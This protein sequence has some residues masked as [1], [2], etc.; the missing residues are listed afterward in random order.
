M[1][2]LLAMLVMAVLHSRAPL[3][4][5]VLPV[6]ILA[7]LSSYF[8]VGLTIYRRNKKNLAQAPGGTLGL[9]RTPSGTL[10]F[11]LV[12]LLLVIAIIGILSSITLASINSSRL[13]AKESAVISNLNTVRAE[14]ELVYLNSNQSYGNPAAASAAVCDNNNSFNTGIIASALA[15]AETQGGSQAVCAV[16]G[17]GG[18]FAVSVP[19]VFGG[20][21]CVFSVNQYSQSLA[22]NASGGGA[23]P[24]ACQTGGSPPPPPPGNVPGNDQGVPI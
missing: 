21:W 19:L 9:V 18:S 15:A 7:V 4:I 24:A 17:G 16:G 13:K 6:P 2:T 1:A 8:S 22:G 12:E 10:G 14:M 23:S 11:T 20:S 3:I 5:V